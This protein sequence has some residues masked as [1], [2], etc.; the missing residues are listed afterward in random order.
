MEK[1]LLR[2]RPVQKYFRQASIHLY[3]IRHRKLLPSISE[4]LLTSAFHFTKKHT[5]ITNQEIDIIMH[6]R[7]S[8]LLHNG[9]PWAKKDN[10]G[11]FNVTMGSFY[12][13]EVSELVGLCILNNL[14]NK[15]GTTNNIELHRYDGLAIFKNT[16]GPQAERTRK[17]ITR[18]FKEH[19]LKITIQ[20][21]LKSV[22]YLDITLNLTNGFFQPYR[23]PND[24]PLYIN[25]KSNHP[26]TVIKQIS[27]AIK[28]RLSALYSK[29]E[30]FDNAEPLYDK[31]LRS[32]GFNESLHNCKKITSTHTKRNKKRNIN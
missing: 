31:A 27:V 15:Y 17:E 22:D 4:E 2:N 7:K 20:S 6:S 25:T 18:C 5:K 9:S 3:R 14:A 10:D 23:K 19:G 8:I 12:G 32:S 24:E 13:A 28:R 29:E 26:P 21:N 30:T 1:L 16:T 11:L